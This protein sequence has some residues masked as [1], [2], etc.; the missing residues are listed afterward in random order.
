MPTRTGFWKE[1]DKVLSLSDDEFEDYNGLQLS[2]FL[3]Q[4]GNLSSK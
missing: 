3:A 2:N 1:L 4:Y